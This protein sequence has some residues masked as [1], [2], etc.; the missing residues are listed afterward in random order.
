[1]QA[2]VFSLFQWFEQIS[3]TKAI[4]DSRWMS[5]GIWV[6]HFFGLFLLVGTSAIINLRILGLAA[7]SASVAELA[8]RL[9]PFTWV[10]YSIAILTGFILFAP[11]ATAFIPSVLFWFKLLAILLG[12][13]S[14]LI[15]HWNV[16]KWDQ[17]PDLPVSAK[18]T[19]VISLVLWLGAILLASAG[20]NYG[21]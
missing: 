17:T 16:R 3:W 8:E 10:G 21:Y 14:T 13:G 1:M 15:I 2:L 19:A 12:T 9:F 5:P 20:I 7:R 18:L 11:D 4:E 6:S